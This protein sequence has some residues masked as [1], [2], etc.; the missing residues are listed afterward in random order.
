MNDIVNL[1]TIPFELSWDPLPERWETTPDSAM[2]ITAGAKTDLFSD[3]RGE[4]TIAN[5]PRLLFSPPEE[6]LLSAHVA[7]EFGSTF[8]AGV[9]LVYAGPGR[10]AKLCF[11]YS[12][13]QQPM[14]VSVVTRDVSDDANG[15]PIEGQAVHLRVARLGEAFAFHYSTD[16]R[17]WHLVR[18]FSLGTADSIQAGF[19]AQS[20][21]GPG[22]TARFSDIRYTIE[23]LANLR[24][25]T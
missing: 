9:L 11:E 7:V 10:W 16:D 1:A 23:T 17:F 18:Y 19:S 24:D 2:V 8:D 5:S 14:V 4:M 15:V 3:P 20:P 22:C 6:Y 12:P 13:Q 21:T 25:G